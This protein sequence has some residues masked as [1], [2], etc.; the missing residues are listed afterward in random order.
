MRTDS[1]YAYHPLVLVANSSVP[2]TRWLLSVESTT[3]PVAR[4]HVAV[5]SNVAIQE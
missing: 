1:V 5:H 2:L 4:F 3:S